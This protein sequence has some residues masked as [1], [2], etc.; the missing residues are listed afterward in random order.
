MTNL[1]IKIDKDIAYF[2]HISNHLREQVTSIERIYNI[3]EHNQVFVYFK[4][5]YSVSI[6]QGWATFDC[7]EIAVKKDEKLLDYF[8]EHKDQIYRTQDPNELIQIMHD[9]SNL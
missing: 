2:T 3:P 1:P 6:L 9:V 7:L 8:E 5:E 4:N